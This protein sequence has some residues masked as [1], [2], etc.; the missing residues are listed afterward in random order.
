MVLKKNE[1]GGNKWYN[2]MV[3]TLKTTGE[4]YNSMPG[5]LKVWYIL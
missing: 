5:A 3:N 1:K 2:V 4:Y